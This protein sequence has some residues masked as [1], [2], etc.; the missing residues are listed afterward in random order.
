MDILQFSDHIVFLSPLPLQ[1][2]ETCAMATRNKR[3]REILLCMCLSCISAVVIT[4]VLK[5]ISN[6]CIETEG[7]ISVR[8][9]FDNHANQPINTLANNSIEKSVLR[10]PSQR[11]PV[12]YSILVAS[13]DDWRANMSRSHCRELSYVRI[14]RVRQ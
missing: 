5:L 11:V 2:Q 6:E 7:Y 14:L 13:I 10:Q 1:F 8:E 9:P 12:M 4:L 3:I